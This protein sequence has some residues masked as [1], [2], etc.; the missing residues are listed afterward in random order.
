[1]KTYGSITELTSLKFREDTYEITV[2][3]NQS[4]TYTAARDVQLPPGDSAHVIVSADATQT[5]TAKTLTAPDINGGT[6]DSLTSLS[7]RDTSAA[8]D[9]TIAAVSSSALSAGRTLTLDVVNAARSLKLAGNLDLAA[10]LTTS[11]ANA[12]TLTTTG[13]TDVTLPTSGT[14]YGTAT[15]SISSAALLAS[16]SDE[17]GTGALVFATSPT[18]VTPSLGTPSALVL[19]NATGLPLST[20]VTGQLPPAN[21]GMGGYTTTVTAAGTTQL[22]VNSTYQQYFTGSNTQTC[23]MPVASTLT[24]GHPFRIVN[25]SSDAVTVTSSGGNIITTLGPTTVSD[26]ICIVASG[27]GAASWSASSVP[28]G[29]AVE[30]RTF[31]NN[32]TSALLRAMISDETGTGS[33]VFATS[34]TLVTPVLGTPASGTMTNVTGLPISTGVSGLGSNVADF[35]ATP[36][37]ANLRTA[38]TDETGTGSA[39][40]ATSPTI[41]TPTINTGMVLNDEAYIRLEDNTGNE[42]VGITAPATV[43]ASYTVKLPAAQGAASEVLTNDGSGNLTWGA[44]LG[45]GGTVTDL[46]SIDAIIQ[47]AATTGADADTSLTVSSDRIQLVTP[48]VTRNYTL[49]T[50]SVKTGDTY[51]ITNLAAVSSSNLC[52]VVKSSDADVVR[53]V[54]PGTSCQVVAL[55]D[56]PTDTTHWACITPAMSEWTE[57]TPTIAGVTESSVVFRFRRVGD[58]LEVWGKA[59]MN[60]VSATITISLPSIGG[61]ASVIDTTKNI[62]TSNNAHAIYGLA[63]ATDDSAGAYYQGM[64]TYDSTTTVRILSLAAANYWSNNVPMTWA[65]PDIMAVQFKVPISGW[66]STKG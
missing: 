58:T 50:T 34:P 30:V 47:P 44:V 3:G 22:T 7:I 52:V 23:E 43:S 5:L 8:Y 42:Y 25:L 32:A 13:S 9:V 26:L 66:T 57:Y 24:V 45:N 46:T 38:L 14:L 27:T 33:L 49:P 37:S 41:T 39:V 10:N 16:M 17:T 55:Q 31:L 18:L 63:E 59:T 20:G 4:T 12:L 65:S 1:M 2:R 61:V 15:G 54:T 6:T 11:G 29:M 35:L 36:S 19:T 48:T 51:T 64:V 60:T 56:T 21:G 28:N 62:G 40:F 53:I